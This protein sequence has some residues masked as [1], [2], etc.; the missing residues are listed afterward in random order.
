MKPTL[1]QVFALSLLGLATTLGLLFAIVLN[2]SRATIIES[3]E[4]IR[5]QASSEI[6]ERVTTFLSKAPDTV[7]A[8]QRQ[9]KLGLIDPSDAKAVESALFA[10][11]LAESDISEITLTCGEQTGFNEDG[12][13]QLAATPRWQLSVVRST[14]KKDGEHLWSRYIYQE[15]AAFVADRRIL[16]RNSTLG[17]PSISRE[18]GTLVSD[19]TL[20]LT[21]T[22]PASRDFYGQLLWSDLHWSQLDANQPQDR[23]DIEVSV[24]QTVA[25]ASDKFA[26]VIRV[27]L[28]AE[29]LDRAVQLKLTPAKEPDPHRIFLSDLDGQLI[30]RGVGSDRA[31]VSGDD[32][33][34][35]PADLAPEIASALAEP[36]LRAVERKYAGRIR[37]FSP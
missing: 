30:T 7:A 13:I 6:S 3:S 37:K 2:E 8:F 20:H 17:A 9:I 35:A 11:L 31:K 27:G 21:F 14:D 29:Q 15:N 12:A 25:D 16:Q 22:T 36:K 18:S 19:P 4:R 26:G 23:R 28:L 32:L 1:G 34:I 10:L 33:R 5:A 24:Q